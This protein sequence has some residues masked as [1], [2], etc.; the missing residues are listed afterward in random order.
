MPSSSQNFFGGPNNVALLNFKGL[1]Q[2]KVD[3]YFPDYDDIMKNDRYVT[4]RMAEKVREIL[5]DIAD[6]NKNEGD[7][8]GFLPGE[9][10]I[11][12]CASKLREMIAA[13][14]VL[15]AK[16]NKYLSSLCTVA[17]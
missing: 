10:F 8:L 16:R 2:H 3:A 5:L 6:G 9:V 4:S 13:D 11:E 7:I 17:Y 12:D 14:P 15:E 1:K